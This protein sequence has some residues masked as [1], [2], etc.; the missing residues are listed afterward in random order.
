MIHSIIRRSVIFMD[1]KYR[2][3]LS[4][5]TLT[6]SSALRYQTDLLFNHSMYKFP[7]LYSLNLLMKHVICL[8]LLLSGTGLGAQKVFATE[9]ASQAQVKVFVVRYESQADLKV[10]KVR[11]D[12][13]AGKNNGK[14]FFTEYGSQAA[15]KIF[16][17]DR[18]S[19]ADLKI[20]FVEY[21]SQ[22]GWRNPEKKHLME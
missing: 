3:C 2:N 6:F 13:Q 16:F 19:S 12:S 11:Y 9:Y 15:K 1:E 7:Y 8:F 20:V 14:W 17:T 18:E 21:D 10:V 4:K 22:A 5:P